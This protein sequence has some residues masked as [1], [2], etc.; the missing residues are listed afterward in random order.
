MRQTNPKCSPYQRRGAGALSGCEVERD[1][2]GKLLEM[3]GTQ[4]LHGAPDVVLEQAEEERP[5]AALQADLVVVDD[6]AGA[7]RGQGQS[8]SAGRTCL[9][10][11]RY[12]VFGTST[13]GGL[14]GIGLR[15][16]A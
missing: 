6:R 15:M 5:V 13:F 4:V 16:R 7:G 10:R 12:T 1:P 11:R 9:G 8:P 3:R 2:A 14:R